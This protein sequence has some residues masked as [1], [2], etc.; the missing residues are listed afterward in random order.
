MIARTEKEI[1]EFF[2]KEY[3]TD[4]SIK[5]IIPLLSFIEMQDELIYKLIYNNRN[6]EVISNIIEYQKDIYNSLIFILDNFQLDVF[7][8]VN[9]IKKHSE[10][11]KDINIFRKA[12]KQDEFYIEFAIKRNMS[13]EQ[14]LE[15]I[16]HDPSCIS[17]L[18]NPCQ[19][20]L[21]LAALL[22]V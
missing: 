10:K 19:E 17:K 14:Q 4:F 8:I 21:D 13:K 22:K 9:L 18:P 15:L 6:Y 20:A 11:L 16:K 1:L 7:N 2:G 3:I 12:I 5:E